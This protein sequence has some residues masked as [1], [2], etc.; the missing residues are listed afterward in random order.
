M[1]YVLR[2][3]ATL[4]VTLLLVSMITFL[5]FQIMPGDP[6][7]TILGLDAEQQQIDAL[8]KEFNL[9]KTITERYALWFSDF[10]R[11]DLGQ[12]IRFN[13]PVDELIRSRLPVTFS[14]TIMSFILIII[15]SIPLGIM[16]ARAHGK[17]VDYFVKMTT[18]LGM[19]IPSFWLGILLMLLF[20][21]VLKMFT[22]IGYIPWSENP[23]EAFKSLF[24]PA[25]AIAIPQIAIVVRYL[26]SSLIEQLDLDYVRTA[27]S[28]GLEENVIIYKHV[29][30]NSLIPVITVMGMIIAKILIGSIV[31]EQVYSLPGL[32]RL[33]VASISYRDFPLIQGMIM[34]IATTVIVINFIV[35][36]LY[37]VL[38]PRI[39]LG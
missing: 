11:G 17:W 36:V 4:V 26:R 20:G 8:R 39:R 30:R 38:D 9:D 13:A 3:G 24:L 23:V 6:A 21:M 14:L 34:R 12:S 37:R 31:L 1:K 32:G 33:L 7:L 5:I 27:H 25:V 29:L 19:A 35:D 15:F 22:T 18:Q 2:R 10:I 16:A 28:K